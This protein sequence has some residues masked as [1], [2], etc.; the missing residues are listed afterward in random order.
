MRFLDW[1]LNWLSRLNVMMLMN[2]TCPCCSCK[3]VLV[4]Q[5]NKRQIECARSLCVGMRACVFVCVWNLVRFYNGTWTLSGSRWMHTHTGSC[6]LRVT[7]KF[8]EQL[9]G[10]FFWDLSWVILVSSWCKHWPT[11]DIQILLIRAK[12]ARAQSKRVRWQAER[13]VG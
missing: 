5:V 6:S 9:K 2:L 7:L 12:T 11:G 1:L 4:F 8:K 10:E 3:F 13:K